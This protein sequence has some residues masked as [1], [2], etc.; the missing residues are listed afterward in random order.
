MLDCI[1]SNP[2][3]T[4]GIYGSDLAK[5]LVAVEQPLWCRLN[6]GYLIDHGFEVE[7][8]DAEAV[9]FGA[10]QSAKWIVDRAPRL[11]VIAVYGHQPSASTQQM[12][13]AG[14]LATEIRAL[15]RDQKII[16]IGNHPSA[17][18]VRTLEEEDVDYV[19]DGEGPRTIEG[20]L[21]G[22]PLKDIP[23]LVYWDGP[24]QAIACNDRAALLDLDKDLHGDVWHLLDMKKYRAHNWQCL[25]DQRRRQPYAAIYTSLG[26]SYKC[27][28]CMINV[29]QHTNRYRMRSP[30]AVVDEMVRLYCDHGVRTFKF[31]D[32]LFVLNKRHC[33]AICEGIIT[34][35][36]AD[37]ISIWCYSRTDTF[38]PAMLP[39]FRRAGFD[40]FALG[41]E[42]GSAEVRAD[43]RKGMKG[44]DIVG[45]VR[46]IEAAGINVI[47]NYIFG[48]ENDTI[49]TM[50]ETLSLAM[51]L[52]TDWANFYSAMAY[53]G[54]PLHDKAVERGLALPE[55]TVGWAGYSQHAY[56]CL[57]LGTSTLTPAEVLR[58]R[59]DA[60]QAYFTGKRYQSKVYEKFG[61]A[62][63]SHVRNMATYKLPRQI[64]GDPRRA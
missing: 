51:Y 39:L 26:C 55:D 2:G 1:I 34:A 11:V 4:H 22:D 38:D 36:M 43:S 28:F 58:F 17:L 37:N 62:A 46:M 21:N 19:C 32:E 5:S 33:T 18:P 44:D 40:W 25:S 27:E 7:I 61:P 63:L 24:E 64:L 13:G 35:G 54:A 52:N 41:I 23:G 42:S 20:L 30:N 48:L 60:F 9:G 15:N 45:Q 53:P 8:L 14:A 10:K 12:V 57:P 3:A 16:M 47:G 59:D 56:E 50:R 6:A 49:E 29:F 31:I